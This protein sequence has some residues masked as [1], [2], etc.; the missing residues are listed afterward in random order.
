MKKLTKKEMKKMI[1]EKEYREL[2]KLIPPEC[3]C[4]R[5]KIKYGYTKM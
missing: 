3:V 5:C 4:E 2:R 1:K